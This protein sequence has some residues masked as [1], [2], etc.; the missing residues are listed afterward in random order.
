[1]SPPASEARGGRTVE[2]RAVSQ[3]LFREVLHSGTFG[4]ELIG[5]TVG[6]CRHKH[7]QM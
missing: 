7:M 5:S 6:I 2:L 4:W 1:M 3:P